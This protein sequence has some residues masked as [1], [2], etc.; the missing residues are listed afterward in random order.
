MKR[1]TVFHNPG[2]GEG[3]YSKDE[4]I[5][6][7]RS[8]GF[9][10]GYSSTKKEINEKSLH[11]NSDF[12]AVAG[13]DGTVKSLVRFLLD[14][15]MLSK[16]YNIGILPAGT[17]NNIARTLEIDGT[18]DEIIKNWQKEKIK[19]FDVVKIEGLKGQ[20]FFMEG[21][22]FGVFPKLIKY[23]KE[24][25]PK[26]EDPDELLQIALKRLLGIVKK[27]RPRYCEIIIDDG[28]SYTGEYLM[29]EVMNI[30][31][32][33]PNLN[34]APKA[35]PGDGLLDVILLSEEHREQ[36]IAYLENRIQHGKQE[37]FFCP[38]LK[39]RRVAVKWY[40]RLLHTDDEL[41]SLNQS[42]AINMEVY[43]KILTFLR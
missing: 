23:M 4:L 7:V 34:I 5:Q 2:A 39:A 26:T 28:I 15:K 17:A 21:F 22:G 36:L 14:R 6:K 12:L 18:T 20:K 41:I 9:K 29:V 8:A 13:G 37:I 31:S 32:I 42:V 40:G 10:C 27:Y 43:P 38:S 24:S 11:G 1:V 33:G 30:R 25:R 3:E 19:H 35:D 16:R